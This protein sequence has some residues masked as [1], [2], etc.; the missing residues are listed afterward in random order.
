MSVEV[1]EQVFVAAD[2][3]PEVEVLG[4]PARQVLSHER[5][6]SCQQKALSRRQGEEELSDLDL[7][8]R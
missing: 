5:G 6:T 1:D 8:P 4:G 2:D 3:E 7:E